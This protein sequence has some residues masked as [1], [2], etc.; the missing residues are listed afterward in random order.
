VLAL[1]C[2]CSACDPAPPSI[3]LI[4]VD[5]LRA[6]HLGA[7]GFD[8][9]V[10]P[11]FDALA[12][13]SAVFERALA[14]SSR[15]APSHAS[16]MTSRWVSE[17][18]IG[19]I[20]GAS[21]L[22]E[23]E[24]TLAGAFQE[25]G[26]E[27]AAFVS[28]MMLRRRMGFDNG[29]L[30]Y[31]D[32]LLDREA[33]RMV[34]ERIADKTT[35][36]A[37]RW[38]AEE[39][40]KPFF[41]WVH[42]N[43]PHGPYE[44]P[45]PYDTPL[46]PANPQERPL[47]VLSTHFGRNG[48]PSYQALPNLRK[49]SEYRHRYAGEIRYFDAALGRLLEAADRTATPRSLI[50]LLTADHGESMGE[51]GHYFSH[52]GITT[53]DVAHVPFLL[54]APGVEATRRSELVHHVDVLP[55]LLELVGLPVPEDARGISLGPALRDATPVPQRILFT[56]V[57]MEV[58]AYRGNQFFRVRIQP[59]EQEPEA[60]APPGSVRASGRGYQWKDGA[61]FRQAKAEPELRRAVER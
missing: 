27:T 10:S 41:L 45:P 49:P 8:P 3:L 29:F 25:A 20:N 51:Q 50:V 14:A 39:R 2:L 5:T 38:L 6:D 56:D 59:P 31:D 13:E 55:T 16:I 32:V 61:R 47:P 43:D 60:G 4:T 11:S 19:S 1:A 58:S 21:R 17:H 42:Y 28:N 33:N 46:S 53:P 9:E 40:E 52:G 15:T 48:I 35:E 36:R 30:F 57:G 26:W 24:R 34:E 44:P 18:S 37:L 12:S 22:L 7:Y 23:S 54:R